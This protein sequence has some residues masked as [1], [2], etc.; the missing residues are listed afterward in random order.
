MS[1]IIESLNK[2]FDKH[3][4]VFW[5][6]EKEEMQEQ[7]DE[8]MLDDVEKLS[9]DGNE[10]EVKYKVVKE[11]PDTKFL[12]YIPGARKSYTDNWLFDLEL[13]YTVFHT[14]QA[15][16]ILQEI[17][18]DYSF[19]DLVNEHL[20]FFAKKER[21]AALNS[22]LNEGD[23]INKI[24]YKMLAIV[25][26]VDIINLTSFIHSHGSAF[27]NNK[28]EYDKQL[29]RFHLEEFYWKEI[30]RIYNY[31]SETPSIYDF[32]IEVF[33]NNYALGQSTG[34]NKESKLLLKQW[35]ESQKYRNDFAKL[36]DKI[37]KD[38]DIESKISNATI[39][40][41][42]HGGVFSLCDIKII[43]NLKTLI[44]DD[45][46]S[47][48][49]V[50]AAVKSRMNKF[51]YSDFRHLYQALVTSSEMI[52][53]VKKYADTKYHNFDEGVEDYSSKLY[54]IDYLYRKFIWH[55]RKSKQNKGLSEL[56]KKVEKVYS[57][58]WLFTFNNNWQSVI[59]NLD[60][61]PDR[62]DNAQ[63]HFF[64]RN[65]NPI[66]SKGQRL[67]V[68]ISDALRYENGHELSKR[69]QAEKR[70]T[71]TIEPMVSMLP[72]Y[73]QLGMAALLPH[74]ELSFKE[75]SDTII[76][77]GMSTMGTAGRTKILQANS[78]V[79]AVAIKADEFTAMN[80]STVGREFVKKYDLIYLYHNKIDKTG[81]D[82]VSEE[83]VFEAVE[84]EF[85]TLMD[86]VSKIAN[87]NGN[88]MMITADHGYIYQH[89]ALDESDFATSEIKGD[90]WKYNRRFVIGKNLKS[91]ESNRAFKSTQLGLSSDN[92][93][94]IPK[95]INRLR[96]KGSGSRFVHG[97]ATLQ[98]VVI[99]L[100]K[101]T[102][103]RKD[104]TTFV[105]VDIIKSSDKITSNT[106]AVS[107]IQSNLVGDKILPRIMRA[108]IYAEDGQLLSDQFTY[109]FDI[110]EGTERQ[111]EV[112][113]KFQ[114]SS[115]ASTDYKNQR[116]KL[117]LEEPIKK[118]SKWKQYKEY[119]YNLSISF[120]DEFDEF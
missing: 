81:D 28:G 25:F 76:A 74:K 80:S 29:K 87:M 82:M 52:Q 61:W 89:Q 103:K 50:S 98:E 65:V 16:M 24:K 96:V 3:R 72:S 20:D 111:R 7:F 67:F 51:W 114:L 12:L 18:L 79:R 26:K 97:G 68:I 108:A 37:S 38:I 112:K 40:D 118:A 57:N 63:Q 77:D 1:K 92:D 30:N 101:V 53:L 100:I 106:L 93:V 119:S 17:G 56:A 104:T 4:I 88:N 45:A 83:N 13:T 31:Q 48:D 55:Y 70:Y 35:Q 64:A 91:N 27:I 5:Y 117:I 86:L 14:D 84:D 2:L 36:S 62:W 95:S 60:K 116:V 8:L 110:D 113:H 90:I 75:G 105:D 42:L 115:K 71:A 10:F 120:A 99:P 109:T 32:L 21:K 102:R 69:L 46:I 9:V 19:K 94:L 49:K 34:V 47:S 73:T 66:V 33:N 59:D 85:D 39:E 44:V 107:F 15:A 11:A 43:Q 54:Q 22:L 78:G 58:D 41:I 23:S 6:D